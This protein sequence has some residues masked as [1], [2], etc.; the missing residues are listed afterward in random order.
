MENTITESLRKD[1]ETVVNDA[2]DKIYEDASESKPFASGTKVR[3]AFNWAMEQI[4][5]QYGMG[6]NALAI[7]DVM[8]PK[9]GP[10]EQ[11]LLAMRIPCGDAMDW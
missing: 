11:K 6:Y 9:L 8:Y 10:H 4:K 5:N 2:V 1:V 7:L 3:D